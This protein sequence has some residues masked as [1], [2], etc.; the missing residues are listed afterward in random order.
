MRPLLSLAV[1]LAVPTG[2]FAVPSEPNQSGPLQVL[3]A[4]WLG[5]SG[6][7]EL[8]D[9]AILPDGRILLAG[10][11]ELLEQPGVTATALG[12]ESEGGG[13][14][15]VAML[16]PDGGEMV[17]LLTMPAEAK[18]LALDSAGNLYVLG[19]ASSKVEIGGTTGEG[20]FITRVAMDG[21]SEAWTMFEPKVMDFGIDGNGD[22]VVL[23]KALLKR[24][25]DGKE[26]WEA[27]W[28]S[29]GDNRPAGMAISPQTGEVAV[30]GYG[31]T[32]T[33]REPWKDP[34]AYG[35][36]RDGKEIWALW[37]PNPKE[38]VDAKYGGTGLMA[39]SM[40]EF[41]A[42]TESGE[43]LLGLRAD[44]GN[45]VLGKN[46]H[47]ETKPL[48]KVLDDVFQKGPGHGFKGASGT[49]VIFRANA[50][51]GD[52]QKGTFMSAWLTPQ[53]ANTLFV[54]DA[55]GDSRG[56]VFVVGDSASGMPVEKGWWEAP[57]GGYLGGGFLAVFDRDFKRLQSGYF[58]H[59]SILTTAERG[60]IVVIAGSAK[61]N[62]TAGDS[63]VNYPSPTYKPVQESFGGGERDGYYVVFKVK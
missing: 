4:G 42:T 5:G 23:K 37:N 58:P 48:E 19:D 40:G 45:T 31:M 15:F 39:D 3:A 20:T 25:R 32:H 61:E 56:R 12:G 38:Q 28:K 36:D 63:G 18:K 9:T 16:S 54:K 34:Y 62:G 8:V 44:G 7:E 43:F 17:A 35:F 1:L 55:A 14:G 57:E 49:S 6:N 51:S 2:A 50:K 33:G 22:V 29:Y 47:D 13:D 60:G 26:V 53:R 52:L 24:F 11:G 59:S 27:K 41:L 21:R 30:S 46:P 10:N